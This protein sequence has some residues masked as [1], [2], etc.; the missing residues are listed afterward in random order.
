MFRRPGTPRSPSMLDDHLVDPDLM[1]DRTTDSDSTTRG[2]FAANVLARD[3]SC[4]MTG[5]TVVQVCHII[6]HS[7]GHQVCLIIS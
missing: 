1:D 7:K 5:S 6:P 2:D 4:V 3:N